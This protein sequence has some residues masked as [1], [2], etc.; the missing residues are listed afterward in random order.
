MNRQNEALHL[1]EVAER[2]TPT[3][4]AC[5]S[6]TVAVARDGALWLECAT[7]Q[8]GRSVLRRVASLD[9]PSAHVRTLVAEAV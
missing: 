9:F 8:G 3:C 6:P 4:D 1:L 2:D 5:G 7:L